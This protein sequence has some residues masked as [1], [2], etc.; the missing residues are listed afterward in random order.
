MAGQEPDELTDGEPS[1]KRRKVRKGTQSCWQCK[2]R[3]VRC[4]FASPTNTICD[5]CSRRGTN[6]I[7]QEYPDEPSTARQVEHRLGRVEEVVALL[8]RK[9]IHNDKDTPEFPSTTR[10]SS[11][12]WNRSRH[13]PQETAVTRER[14]TP[15]LGQSPEETSGHH[16]LSSQLAAL[17]PSQ[18]DLDH[19]LSLPTRDVE[20]LTG[21]TCALYSDFSGRVTPS[22]EDILQLPPPGSHPILL[23]RKLLLLG[24]HLQRLKMGSTEE[25]GVFTTGRRDAIMARLIETCGELVTCNDDLVRSVEGIECIMIESMYHNNSGNFRHSWLA[26]RRAMVI[27]QLMGLHCESPAPRKILQYRTE[28]CIDPDAIWFRLT[29]VDRYLSM[30]LGLPMGHLEDNFAA[31]KALDSCWPT[32]RMQRLQCVAMGR[33]LQHNQTGA[34]NLASVH[35]IDTL[36]REASSLMPPK[37]WLPPGTGDTETVHINDLFAHYHLLARLHF[38]YLLR[39]SP[40]R[41]YDYSKITAVNASREIISWFVAFRA[42]GSTTAYCRGLDYMILTASTTL[43]IAHLEARRQSQIVSS[44]KGGPKTFAVFDFLV[45]QRLSDRGMMERALECMQ[46]MARDGIDRIAAKVSR[47]LHH[48]LE[49]EADAATG[50]TYDT[51]SSQGHASSIDEDLGCDGHLSD[52]GNALHIYI[53]YFGT[54]LIER[55]GVSKSALAAPDALDLGQFGAA[56]IP[57]HWSEHQQ[58]LKRTP[59]GPQASNVTANSGLRAVPTYSSSEILSEQPQSTLDYHLPVGFPNMGEFYEGG[60]PILG[61]AVDIDDWASQSMD[62]C[63]FDNVLWD[64]TAGS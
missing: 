10:S 49:I 55:G 7:S 4:T 54:V 33:I 26:T 42:P 5:A 52:G 9:V 24:S 27:A 35:E 47:I 2:S 38:P 31:P 22:P 16:E 29:Q 6:C 51:N 30:M 25:M 1:L 12:G 36:I 60:F 53:P 63:L 40:D 58:Q 48:L 21:S 41:M 34:D 56:G 3:K 28:S 50:T 23:A 46:I 32:E 8:A 64:S 37:W 62:A 61:T 59:P 45:H 11:N 15:A 20:L 39:F 43:C 18:R 13:P 44:A 19:I 17:W 57:S 14:A